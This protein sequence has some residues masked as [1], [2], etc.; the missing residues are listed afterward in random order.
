MSKYAK[1]QTYSNADWE[2]VQGY[3]RGRKNLPMERGNA[4]YK[5]GWLNG[6]DDYLGRPRDRANVLI[7][8][9]NMIPGITPMAEIG[10][11]LS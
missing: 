1:P 6:Q 9:A 3:M 4:A 10:V 2:M 7:R 5:H 11:S 8:R